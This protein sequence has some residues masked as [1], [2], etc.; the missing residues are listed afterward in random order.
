M[1][2][3]S[4]IEALHHKHAQLEDTIAAEALRPLPDFIHLHALKKQK[5]AVK[6]ELYTLLGSDEAYQRT[7]PFS[8]AS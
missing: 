3:A 6:E 4:H 8:E 7:V 2:L 1:S 5:L